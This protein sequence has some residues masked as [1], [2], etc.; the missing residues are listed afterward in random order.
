M[1]PC[2]N[3]RAHST[4]SISD[5]APDRSAARAPRAPSGAAPP[6]TIEAERLRGLEIDDQLELGCQLNLP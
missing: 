6:S 3:A 5:D 4:R 2:G 1:S